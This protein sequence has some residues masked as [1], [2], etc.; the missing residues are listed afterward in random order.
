[1]NKKTILTT[2]ISKPELTLLETKSIKPKENKLLNFIKSLFSAE[3]LDY[4]TWEKIESR[5]YIRDQEKIYY[6]GRFYV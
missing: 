1:M 6:H 3:D 5:Q 4:K 2:T